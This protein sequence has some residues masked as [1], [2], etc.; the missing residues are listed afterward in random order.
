MSSQTPNINLTL[1]VGSENVSR[2]IINENNTKIDAAIGTL[3]GSV[4]TLQSDVGSLSDSIATKADE[5]KL[6]LRRNY[7]SCATTAEIEN[8]VSGQ[9]ALMG[10]TAQTSVIGI[11]V[12]TTGQKLSGGIWNGLLFKGDSGYYS[13]LF[14]SYSGELRQ[15]VYLNGSKSWYRYSPSS[16]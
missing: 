16:I 11:T 1:P 6:N 15:Y 12:S 7:I 9:V 8:A 13:C 3:N 5:T 2:Q 10:S 4:A 14:Y